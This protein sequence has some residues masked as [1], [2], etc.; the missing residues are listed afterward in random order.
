[1]YC[2]LYQNNAPLNPLLSFVISTWPL[3]LGLAPRRLPSGSEPK[4]E[5]RNRDPTRRLRVLP[6]H[7]H[8][9]SIPS[10]LWPTRVQQGY[11]NTHRV[12]SLTSMADGLLSSATLRPHCEHTLFAG[13]RTRMASST[14]HS[15]GKRCPL[16]VCSCAYPADSASPLRALSHTPVDL[17]PRKIHSHSHSTCSRYRVGV[18][19]SAP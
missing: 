6:A 10:H 2:N 15:V 1:M 12:T 8:A 13:R 14:P 16:C 18:A 19:H 3:R 7:P 11:Y 9:H 5:A 4:S 17:S